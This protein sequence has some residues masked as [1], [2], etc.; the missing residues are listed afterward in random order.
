M[1]VPKSGDVLYLEAVQQLGGVREVYRPHRGN[2][3]AAGVIAPF[4]A[5]VGLSFI[6]YI[7][8]YHTTFTEIS[9]MGLGAGGLFMMNG[10]GLLHF[11]RSKSAYRVVVCA[12]GLVEAK[13]RSHRAWLWHE[14]LRTDAERTEKGLTHS[15][16]FVDGTVLRF[17]AEAISEVQQLVA[18]VR[19][20]IDRHS[21]VRRFEREYTQ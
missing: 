15:I 11:Y 12:Y 18:V 9:W 21:E 14:I 1:S 16:R 4:T 2:V 5:A 13:R 7:L 3:I 17:D 20:E 10:V 19:A 6:V 8:C